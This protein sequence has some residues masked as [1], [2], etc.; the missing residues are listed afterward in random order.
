MVTLGKATVS[1]APVRKEQDEPTR[2]SNVHVSSKEISKGITQELDY[3]G[4]LLWKLLSQL[5]WHLR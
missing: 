3:F 4:W 5:A 2:K 1:T